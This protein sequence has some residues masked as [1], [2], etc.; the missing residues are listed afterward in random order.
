MVEPLVRHVVE[1]MDNLGRTL[2]IETTTTGGMRAT[3]QTTNSQ[4]KAVRLT[5]DAQQKLRGFLNQHRAEQ[6][7]PDTAP[8]SDRIDA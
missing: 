7:D 4:E 6:P 5:V 1:I 3:I 2:R 8:P